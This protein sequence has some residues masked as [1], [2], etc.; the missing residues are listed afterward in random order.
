MRLSIDPAPAWIVEQDGQRFRAGTVT[1]EVSPLIPLPDHVD[2]WAREV[3]RTDMPANTVLDIVIATDLTTA[4]GW[5][6][7]IVES[8]AIAADSKRI[9]EARLHLFYTL[10]F[11]GALVTV[12]CASPDELETHRTE[13][14]DRLGRARPDWSGTIVA[15]AQILEPDV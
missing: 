1:I 2:A 15:L 12:K 13:I 4:D 14:L 3:V 10:L 8:H 6:L 7:G 11:Y 9:V 5:P